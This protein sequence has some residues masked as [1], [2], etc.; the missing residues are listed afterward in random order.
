[1]HQIKTPPKKNYLNNKDLLAAV[2]ESKQ[3][4]Q[5]SNKLATMLTLLCNKYSKK[6]NFANYSY[7][8]DMQ[9]YA[10]LMLVKTWNAFDPAKSNNPFAFFTQCIKHSFIQYLNQEK[11]QRDI[12]D[13]TLLSCGLSPSHGYTYDESEPVSRLD[14]GLVDEEDFHDNVQTYASLNKAMEQAENEEP[15]TFPSDAEIADDAENL[16][17]EQR[18]GELLTY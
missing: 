5:M 4:G 16:P 13:E 9:S 14:M 10:M 11:R 8:D 15:F 3:N 18:P 6:G 7:N 17:P 1:M 2:I 12:R